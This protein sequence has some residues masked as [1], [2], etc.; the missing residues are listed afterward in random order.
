MG[1]KAIALAVFSPYNKTPPRVVTPYLTVT[2]RSL[3]CEHQSATEMLFKNARMLKKLEQCKQSQKVFP[4]EAPFWCRKYVRTPT[5]VQR[6]N[7]CAPHLSACVG[8]VG[9]V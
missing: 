3:L 2:R 8:S 1:T 7:K 4:F 5:D 9:N 6:G